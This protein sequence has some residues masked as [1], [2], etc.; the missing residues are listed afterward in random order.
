M[1]GNL[2]RSPDTCVQ[3][4]RHIGLFFSERVNTLFTAS[5]SKISGLTRLHVIG[6]V[7]DIFFPLW[8]ADLFFS[9]FAGEF[10]GYVWTVAVSGKKKL[11]IDGINLDNNVGAQN[12]D[13]LLDRIS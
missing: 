12:L 3:V 1:A 2:L 5:D 6:F 11:R 7:A 9:G 8:R 13:L 10:A 4:N